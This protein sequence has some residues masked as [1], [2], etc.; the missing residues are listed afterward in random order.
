MAPKRT[1]NAGSSSSSRPNRFVDPTKEEHHAV[2]KTKGIVQERSIDFPA[3][4]F[5]RRCR[6]PPRTIGGWTST[7]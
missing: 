1:R 4:F 2:I 3:I 5:Y 7:P 6:R